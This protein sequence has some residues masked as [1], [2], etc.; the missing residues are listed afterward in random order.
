MVEELP[1]MWDFSS[2]KSMKVSVL[3]SDYYH[4]S[5][6]NF[7][8]IMCVSDHTVFFLKFIY[9]FLAVLG[10]CCFARAFSSWGERG[11]SLVAVWG[12]LTVGASLAVARALSA[13]ASVVTAHKPSC[14]AACGILPDRDQTHVHRTGVHAKPLQLCPALCSPMDWVDFYLL[15]HR[16]VLIA[17]FW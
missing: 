15:G 3:A 12:L 6:I 10:F 4:T 5:L 9:L 14:S 17:S 16:E 8:Q 11:S 1:E 2:P 13:R 7:S